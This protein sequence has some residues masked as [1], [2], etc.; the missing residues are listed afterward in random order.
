MPVREAARVVAHDDRAKTGE[1]GRRLELLLGQALRPRRAGCQLVVL[2][3]VL[4]GKG[5]EGGKE[6]GE[7]ERTH[8]LEPSV[9]R[10][11]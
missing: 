3:G 6:E 2:A 7:K 5:A 1:R 4:M 10:V 11:V 9:R 8:A